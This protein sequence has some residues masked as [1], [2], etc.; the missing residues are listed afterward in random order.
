MKNNDK[1]SVQDLIGKVATSSGMSK[2]A[3]EDFVRAFTASIDEGLHTDGSVRLKGF[4]TFKLVWNL[5][6]KSVNVR[7][8]EEYIIPGH[9]KLSFVPEE[10]LKTL[11][12]AIEGE[13]KKAGPSRRKKASSSPKGEKVLTPQERLH[14]E[15]ERIKPQLTGLGV[16]TP[17]EANT[18]E[19][20]QDRIQM[21]RFREQADEIRSLLADFGFAASEVDDSV[22]EQVQT[23][24]VP[25]TKMEPVSVK[26]EPVKSEMEPASTVEDLAEPES[27]QTEAKAEGKEP[28]KENEKA[29]AETPVVEVRAEAALNQ[30]EVIESEKPKEESEPFVSVEPSVTAVTT[31]P[32]HPAEQAGAVVPETPSPITLKA[33]EEGQPQPIES[34]DLGER[35]LPIKRG[36]SKWIDWLI[37]LLL[38]CLLAGIL[39]FIEY[40]TQ[41]FST[42]IEKAKKEWVKRVEQKAQAEE[43]ERNEAEIKAQLPDTVIAPIVVEQ[44][45]APVVVND[46]VKSGIDYESYP[47]KERA[48][49]RT[50][51]TLSSIARRNYGHADFW[52]YIYEANIEKLGENLHPDV[53]HVVVVRELPEE[54]VNPK[55]A[56]CRQKA[57]DLAKKYE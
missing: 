13:E 39:F 41:F 53:G 47:I 12:G 23:E 30:T 49:I 16:M 7:T 8:G 19:N 26:M 5:P 54:L 46:K 32:S 31:E 15:A 36:H 2:K 10:Q 48:V 51:E 20:E 57:K 11:F 42:M 50:G 55:N 38:F 33:T 3:V 21:Q 29:E 40:R 6:R 24:S 43:L 17:E 45:A 37:I 52:V 28:E 34:Y 18:E 4:G 1:L 25:V 22:D 44:Q 14:D 56:E 9:N 27:K 35:E